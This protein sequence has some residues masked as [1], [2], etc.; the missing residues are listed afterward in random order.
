MLKSTFFLS[1]SYST[2]LSSAGA[3]LV[4]MSGRSQTYLCSRKNRISTTCSPVSGVVTVSVTPI[5][6]VG[7]CLSKTPSRNMCTSLT[8]ALAVNASVFSAALTKIVGCS[9]S[10]LVVSATVTSAVAS[11]IRRMVIVM[12]STARSITE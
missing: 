4:V 12:R 8:A 9:V 5:V 6:S 1:L 7:Y 11:P 2:Y 3:S 10:I